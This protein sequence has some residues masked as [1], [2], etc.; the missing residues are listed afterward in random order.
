MESKWILHSRTFW[1]NVVTGV[2]LFLALPEFADVLPAWSTKYL[3]LAQAALN[4]V[5]RFVSSNQPVTVTR[6]GGR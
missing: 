4:I 2:S 1:V 5:M 6:D 3:L